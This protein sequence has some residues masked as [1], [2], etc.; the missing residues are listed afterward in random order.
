MNGKIIINPDVLLK[1]YLPKQLLHRE[2]EL[3]QLKYNIGNRV[4]TIMFGSVGSGKTTLLKRVMKDLLTEDIRYVDCLIYST[5]FSVLMEIIPT[6]KLVLQRSTY[7]LIKRLDK[8][9]KKRKLW[10]C[11]DNF[12]RLKDT[13][14]ITKVMSLGVNII[15]VSNVKRD[16]DVLNR[17]VLSNI[18]CIVKLPNYTTE[19][20]FN[21]LR[22]RAQEALAKSSFTDELLVE[23]SESAKGNMALAIN[24]LRTAALKAQGENRKR[25]EI[26]DLSE[27][28]YPSS[29][30]GNLSRDERVLLEILREK[31]R[32]TSGE[33][34]S[35]YKQR[36]ASLKGER[37]FRNYME[38]LCTKGFVR[39]V[40]TN[41]W[42]VYKPTKSDENTRL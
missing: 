33:L 15:L 34:Y 13:S 10:I 11:F 37:S 8:E 18:P 41:R 30:P 23:I 5:A 9:V 4:N 12:V 19:Q 29:N 21:I 39:A 31:G 42:R 7:E 36:A 38:N 2:K 14:I 3:Q 26:T 28:L 40:G 20:S 35:F 22:G 25:I 1:D 32:L 6:A 17:N 24:I 16:A 27:T